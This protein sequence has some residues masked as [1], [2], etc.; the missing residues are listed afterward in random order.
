MSLPLVSIVIPTFN[1]RPQFLRDSLSSALAQT[2][3]QIEV[4]VSDNHSTN[5]TAALLAEYDDPRLRVV[6]PRSI[7]LS[8]SILPSPQKRLAANTSA[9]SRQTIGLIRNGLCG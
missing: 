9:F 3:G 5:G 7:C 8:R 4:I 6:R 2:Y 1:Q